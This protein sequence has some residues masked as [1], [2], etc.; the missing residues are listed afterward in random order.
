MKRVLES[1]DLTEPHTAGGVAKTTR[2]GRPL[3]GSTLSRLVKQGLATKA[4]RG[5]LRAAD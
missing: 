5:Y 1:L 2:L 4:E 3:V